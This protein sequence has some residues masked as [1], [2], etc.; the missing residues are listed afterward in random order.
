MEK[1]IEK[2]FSARFWMAIMFSLCACYGFIAGIIPAELF[3]GSLVLPAVIFYFKREDR[4]DK[5]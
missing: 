3:V 1:H 5:E 4:K 2:L